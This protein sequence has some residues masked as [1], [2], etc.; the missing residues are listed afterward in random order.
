MSEASSNLARYDGIRYGL[1]GED[2]GDWN[3]TYCN[4]RGI[5]FG[6]EVKRRIIL[7]TFALSA[8]YRN[9][10]Y[11]RAQKIRTLIRED[12]GRAFKEFDLIAGPTM[13][14]L[15]FKIGEKLDPLEIYMC[16]IETVPANLAGT[17]AI[18]IPCGM[19]NGLPVGLQLMAPPF[20]EGLLFRAGRIIEELA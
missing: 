3:E 1:R 5:G 6:R 11:I 9:R 14:V 7:G 8:G 20:G 2:G 17:P 13:P 4:N 10:Y 12:L 16:D 18:S 15:P 19:A